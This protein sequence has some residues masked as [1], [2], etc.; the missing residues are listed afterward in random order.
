MQKWKT[1]IKFLQRLINKGKEE[2]P[3]Q[4][5]PET[6]SEQP[7]VTPEQTTPPPEQPVMPEQTTATVEK[8]I[9]PAAVNQNLSSEVEKTEAS[10]Q[11]KSPSSFLEKFKNLKFA[12]P[13]LGK[14]ETSQKI[15]ASGKSNFKQ[16]FVV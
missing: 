6:R 5:T 3:P 16:K 9:E 2:Q 8:T 12:K 1:L 4:E 7:S 11:T 13:S 14:K 15:S 10:T